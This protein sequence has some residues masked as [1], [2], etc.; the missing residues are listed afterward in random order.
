MGLFAIATTAAYLIKPLGKTVGNFGLG[1]LISPL[2][3]AIL[4]GE[5]TGI[6]GV[7]SAGLGSTTS[8]GFIIGLPLLGSSVELSGGVGAKLSGEVDGV[9]TVGGTGIVC[10]V[11]GFLG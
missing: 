8:P 3:L 1:I 9:G 2:G 5:K 10:G 4:P 6:V 11:C 7:P